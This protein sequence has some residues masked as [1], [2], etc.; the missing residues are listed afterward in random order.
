VRRSVISLTLSLMSYMRRLFLAST[1]HIGSLSLTPVHECSDWKYRTHSSSVGLAKMFTA[2]LR[3]VR[4]QYVVIH[5][6]EEAILPSSMEIIQQ[7]L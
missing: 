5:G 7:A 2:R 6:A 3:L 4:M 1:R